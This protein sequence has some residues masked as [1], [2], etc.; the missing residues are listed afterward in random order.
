MNYNGKTVWVTG[1]SSGIG[2]ALCNELASKGANIVLSARRVAELEAVRSGMQRT[3]DHLI[4][5]LD[6]TDRSSYSAA[7]DSILA[8]YGSLH[9]VV[10]NAGIGQRGSVL[11]SSVDVERRIM[12]IN[13]FAVTELARLVL[14]HFH[15]QNEGQIVVM[16]SI[17]GFISTP[18]RTTYAASKHALQGYFEGLRAELH[19]T[20]I[21]ISIV[22][23]GY[24][25]TNIS[26]FA[27][28][29][30]GTPFGEMDDQHRNAMLSTVFARKAVRGLEREKPILFIGGPER[31]GPLLARI[32][33]SIVRF[34]LPKVITR[35]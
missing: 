4:L 8:R 24:I 18:R 2:A 3:E 1:A 33:P 27:Q 35:E 26:V 34:L 14:P 20:N 28:Q 12:D 5:P 32:S 9:S 16:S 30:D 13:Y 21:S 15:E 25:H 6:V 17:M 29:G 7:L 22:C 19:K 31:F 23:P 10:L 11:E